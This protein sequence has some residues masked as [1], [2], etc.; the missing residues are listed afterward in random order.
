MVNFND[1]KYINKRVLVDVLRNTLL[2]KRYETLKV[3]ATTALKEDFL[4]S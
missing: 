4:Q 2:G 1:T 3:R